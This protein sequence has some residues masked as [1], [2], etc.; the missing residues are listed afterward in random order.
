MKKVLGVLVGLFLMVGVC[1]A[2]D[3]SAVATG[4][5]SKLN[6]SGHVFSDHGSFCYFI[7]D[8]TNITAVTVALEGSINNSNWYALASHTFTAG[9]LDNAVEEA[10]FFVA[11]APVTQLRYNLTTLTGGNGTSDAVYCNYVGK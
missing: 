9:E 10:V 2:A 1:S 6:T 3:F 8:G 4:V 5:G 11:N 7:D